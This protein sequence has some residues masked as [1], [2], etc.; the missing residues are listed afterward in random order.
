M[1]FDPSFSR[2]IT[3][4]NDDH[5]CVLTRDS[6]DGTLAYLGMASAPSVNGAVHSVAVSPDG[7]RVYVAAYLD[8]VVVGFAP[9]PGAALSAAA[10]LLVR[11]RW[12]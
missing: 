9:E 12:R 4:Q 5:L 3:G 6:Q 11:R 1:A 8:D 7:R 2:L 10:A